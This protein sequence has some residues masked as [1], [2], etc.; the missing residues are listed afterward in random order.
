MSGRVSIRRRTALLAGLLLLAMAYC[1]AVL[2]SS[3]YLPPVRIDLTADGLYTLTPGTK[4]IIDGVHKPLRLTLYFSEH[5]ARDLPQ[6][7][8]Y[9][10]RVNE[11]LQEMVAR[12]HGQPASASGRSDSVFR[13]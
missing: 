1:A 13:R 8:S 5:A 4:Q 2:V 11:M 7:R 10:Q 9:E 12:S 6:L 3:R